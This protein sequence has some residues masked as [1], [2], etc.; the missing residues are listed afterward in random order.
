LIAENVSDVLWTADMDLRL[1]YISPSIQRMVGFA[2]EEIVGKNAGELLLPAS[3]AQALEVLSEELARE[4]LESTDP[5]RSRV[6][7]LDGIHKNESLIR[8]EVKVSFIRDPDH[9][10]IG[11]L[12]VTRD[13]TKRKQVEESLHRRDAFLEA[14]SLA[15]ERF[16]RTDFWDANP[17]D[18]LGQLGQAMEVS[19]VYIFENRLG[20]DGTLLTSMRF[21]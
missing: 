3:M 8:T 21:E 2:P 14:V 16:L 9:Q 17:T 19:R 20:K 1:T 15:A 5:N 4:E 11:I 6:L 10:P 12:G 18:I 13:I 7:E